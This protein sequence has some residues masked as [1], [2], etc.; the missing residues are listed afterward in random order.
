MPTPDA[1]QLPDDWKK[2]LAPEFAKPYW[3]ELT[4]FVAEERK[5]QQVFPP[6]D[7]VFTAF[8][9]TPYAGVRAVLLGQDPYHDDGQAHGL[10]FSVKPGVT[11]PP[12]LKNM[13]KELKTDLGCKVPNN[14]YLVPWAKQGLLMINAVLTV[15]AH[16]PASHANHGWETFTDA[17]IRAVSDREDPA[18][19]LL[20]GGYAKKKKKLIDAKRHV[21][22]EGAHPSPLSAKLFFGSKPFSQVN[23]ALAKLGKPPID[24]QIPN[25]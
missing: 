10:C 8:H 5:T 16:T 25:L 6:A 2:V 14:G 12:S 4:D 3:Q 23:D 24:W 7:E 15:R 1:S 20:W 11:P 9:L 22:I 13:Y 19:F 21:V 17:A 18:V